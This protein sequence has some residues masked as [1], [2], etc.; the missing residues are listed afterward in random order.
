MAL[1]PSPN[2][3]GRKTMKTRTETVVSISTNYGGYEDKDIILPEG[4]TDWFVNDYDGL[5]SL[6]YVKEGKL[7]NENNERIDHEGN[8]YEPSLLEKAAIL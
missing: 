1:I 5:E 3:V 7:Y 2:S 4:V 8:K 6:W